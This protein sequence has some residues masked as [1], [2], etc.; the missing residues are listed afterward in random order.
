[1]NCKGRSSLYNASLFYKLSKLER[2][3][4]DY[5]SFSSSND[6]FNNDAN[7][8]EHIKKQYHIKSLVAK[9]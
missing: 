3:M 6:N 5:I 8:M 2:C 9:Y 4:K 7:C 1:M